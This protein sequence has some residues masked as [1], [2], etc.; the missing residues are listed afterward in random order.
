MIPMDMCTN[1]VDLVIC[2]VAIKCL[3]ISK[4]I[5]LIDFCKFIAVK[6]DIAY[7]ITQIYLKTN[8]DGDKRLKIN[9]NQH[10]VW[11]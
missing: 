2:Q 4:Q 5:A 7:S 11:V 10:N 6:Y 1:V 8:E 3:N 9:P